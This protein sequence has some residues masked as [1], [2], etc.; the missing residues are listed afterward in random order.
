MKRQQTMIHQ[1]EKNQSIE[2]EAEITEI[3]EI[4]N[5][6]FKYS[7]NK[8]L[9]MPWSLKEIRKSKIED[10][11]RIICNFWRSKIQYLK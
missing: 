9:S 3:I 2:A 11:E 10:I 1:Q 7:Y 4:E 8:Y 5:K 6:G